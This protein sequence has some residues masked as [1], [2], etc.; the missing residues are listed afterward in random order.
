MAPSQ[1]YRL[2]LHYNGTDFNGWQAQ[3]NK[4]SIQDHLEKALLTALREE[5]RVAGASRTDSGVHARHQVAT[6][7]TDKTIDLG[8]LRKSLTSLLPTTVGIDAIT[9]ISS[10]FNPIR[11]AKGK[12]YRY[13]IWNSDR[14]QAF[15]YPYCWRTYTRLDENRMRDMAR[16]F[17]GRHDFSAFCAAN[18]S[19]RT[20]VRTI[21]EMDVIRRGDLIEIWVVGN[22]FLKQMVRSMIGTMVDIVSGKINTTIEQVLAS[23]DRATGGQTAPAS[24]LCLYRIFYDEIQ[25]IES[26]LQQQSE[27]CSFW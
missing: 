14:R 25:T 5:I 22:G 13:W 7:D 11:A 2:D 16:A 20:K 27:H 21:I 12:A 8:I 17:I 10:D 23:K 4:G 18:S 1:R 24:G 19:A 26:M 3:T 6:F 9:P 15:L